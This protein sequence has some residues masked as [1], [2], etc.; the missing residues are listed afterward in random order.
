MY[1]I[2]KY[3]KNINENKILHF[4]ASNM[5]ST[6]FKKINLSLKV[7][8]EKILGIRKLFSSEKIAYRRC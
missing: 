5:T 8:F 1:K 6:Y 7:I 4:S 2:Y 3:I